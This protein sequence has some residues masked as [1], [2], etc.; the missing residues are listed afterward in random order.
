MDSFIDCAIEHCPTQIFQKYNDQFPEPYYINDLLLDKLESPDI[1]PLLLYLLSERPSYQAAIK[2]F[3]RRSTP[4]HESC[5]WTSYFEQTYMF[6][7]DLAFECS[8]EIYVKMFA[9]K[10]IRESIY[11][12]NALQNSLNTFR[13]YSKTRDHIK[14]LLETYDYSYLKQYELYLTRSEGKILFCGKSL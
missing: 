1:C 5:L 6:N 2:E 7:H 14:V 12:C 4:S 10:T 8:Q 11:L 3:I 9:G 13:D